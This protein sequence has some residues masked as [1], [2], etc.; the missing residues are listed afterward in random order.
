MLDPGETWV[1]AALGT[2]VA[3]QYNNT[4]T[5]TAVDA[6]GT[7]ADA[8]HGQR[9][10]LVFRRRPG[11]PDRQIDQRRGQCQCERR[12]RQ[13]RHLDLQRDQHRQR[14]PDA[15]W[16]SP[17]AIRASTRSIRAATTATVC[18]TW[19]RRGSTP[20]RARP[21]PGSTATSAR[22]PPSTPPARWPTPVSAS[23]GDSYFGVQPGI[24][25]VKLTN[26]TRQQHRA[27]RAGRRRQH[28]DL[29]VRRLQQRQRRR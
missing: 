29:D 26:G 10:R 15:A 18:W 19:A 11:Y 21:S 9:R 4:G 3:G 7:V 14:C 23:E 16:R 24:Q 2:A 27:R 28:G 20:P 1:F 8:G 12:R 17:T 6:T 25:I 22:P 5:A 13:R